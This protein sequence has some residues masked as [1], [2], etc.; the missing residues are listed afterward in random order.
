MGSTLGLLIWA[1][2]MLRCDVFRLKILR[3]MLRC[4]VGIRV[5]YIA[6]MFCLKNLDA[7]LKYQKNF[8]KNFLQKFEIFKKCAAG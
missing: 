3:A 7:M 1:L 6:A 5:R 8:V 4:D 2:A